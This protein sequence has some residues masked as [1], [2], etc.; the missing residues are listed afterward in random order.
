MSSDEKCG[1]GPDIGVDYNDYFPTTLSMAAEAVRYSALAR[2]RAKEEML[3][4]R[5]KEVKDL[6]NAAKKI[7]FS[8]Q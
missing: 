8:P 3:E 4:R 6:V 7:V 5:R 2:D 1:K